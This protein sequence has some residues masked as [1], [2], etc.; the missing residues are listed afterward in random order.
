M[1]IRGFITH[2]QAE[3]YEDCQ[4]FFKVDAEKRAVAI[5]DGMSQSI[6]PQWWAE[7]LVNAYLND[8]EP[9]HNTISSLRDSWRS[10]VV[11]FLEEKKAEGE[12]PW[13]LENCLVE[14]RG[15]GATLCGIRFTEDGY[16]WTGHVLGD[17]C[18]ILVGEKHTIRKIYRSQEGEFG[19]HPDYFDSMVG[20]KGEV[21]PIDGELMQGEIMLL[22]TDALAEF[23]YNK[24][25]TNEEESY[26]IQL[27][28]L[29]THEDFCN[30]VEE[31]RETEKLHNDDTTLVVIEHTDVPDFELGKIDDLKGLCEEE[32][33]QDLS[34]NDE[35]K[36][37][38]SEVKEGISVN[39]GKPQEHSWNC[40]SLCEFDKS[41]RK[42]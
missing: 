22:V 39:D 5:S 15:A 30:L 1:N 9:S 16:K 24:H 20:G 23:L 8:W 28:G 31:W 14:K 36:L 35:G 29:K 3:K 11:S 26:V 40:P 7:E 38:L 2:K 21:K 13:M 10:R 33:K 6:F 4:D 12:N 25:K 18:L 17:S 42:Q 27:L 41:R 34:Q 32:E 19:N 37:E